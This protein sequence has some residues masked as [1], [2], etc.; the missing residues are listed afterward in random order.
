MV[1]VELIYRKLICDVRIVA[2]WL[3]LVGINLLIVVL[4]TV[5]SPFELGEFPYSQN[6]RAQRL[7]G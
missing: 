1:R 3:R 6:K 7:L 5:C 4:K 2:M